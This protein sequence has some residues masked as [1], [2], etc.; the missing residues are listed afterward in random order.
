MFLLWMHLGSV[1]GLLAGLGSVFRIWLNRVFHC[2][3]RCLV[4]GLGVAQLALRPPNVE[5]AVLFP[6]RLPLLAVCLDKYERN[7]HVQPSWSR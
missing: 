1:G 4:F 2:W 7:V 3:L 5:G 6:G